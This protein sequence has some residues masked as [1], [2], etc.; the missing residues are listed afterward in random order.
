MAG[1]MSE[2]TFSVEIVEAL[3]AKYRVLPVVILDDA[4]PARNLAAALAGGGLPLAE[5]TFRTDA[6]EAAIQQMSADPRL[7]V[8]AG[9]IINPDQVDRAVAAGARFIVSPGFGAKVVQRAQQLGVPVFPGVS[10]PTEIMTAIDAGLGTV[11][12][13]PAES[14]GGLGAIKALSG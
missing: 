13:F 7:L 12:F 3:I 4:G 6:A 11:K 1:T 2:E 5:V 14:C 9:T 10:T 8:G